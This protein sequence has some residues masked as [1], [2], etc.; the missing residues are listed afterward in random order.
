MPG[1]VRQGNS[2]LSGTLRFEAIIPNISF[3]IT[4]IKTIPVLSTPLSIILAERKSNNNIYSNGSKDSSRNDNVNKDLGPRPPQVGYITLNQ[5]R[6]I[7]PLLEN[8]PIVSL[9]PLVGVWTAFNDWNDTMINNYDSSSNNNNHYN[10][11]Y[12]KKSKNNNTDHD[13]G[14]RQDSTSMSMSMSVSHINNPLTWAISM[15]FLFNEYIKERVFVAEE[16]FLLVSES[17]K[18][19]CQRHFSFFKVFHFLYITNS[20]N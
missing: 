14:Q 4:K 13:H 7:I 3:Q 2:I 6:K 20:T 17:Q 12:S 1:N 15:R 11:N 16:T 19:S 5:T 9:T 10:N 18:R 8:D